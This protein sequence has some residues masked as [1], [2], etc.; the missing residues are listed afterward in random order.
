MGWLPGL[1][2]W[3]GMMFLILMGVAVLGALGYRYNV[4]LQILH[5]QDFPASGQLDASLTVS[6]S[7]HGVDSA[8]CRKAEMSPH[9]PGLPD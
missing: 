8:Y 3:L 9:E 7:R 5:E 2:S 4:G 1:G 6:Q